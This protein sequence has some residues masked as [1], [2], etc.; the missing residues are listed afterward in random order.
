MDTICAKWL[1]AVCATLIKRRAPSAEPEVMTAPRAR[2]QNDPPSPP[3]RLPPRRGGRRSSCPGHGRLPRGRL[4]AQRPRGRR[5]R[6]RGRGEADRALAL[7]RGEAD[8]PALDLGGGGLRRG[9]A[10]AHTQ[11]RE[12][13]HGR[14][15]DGHGRGRDAEPGAVKSSGELLFRELVDGIWLASPVQ[16]YLDLMR[17]EGRARE[18]AKHL[19]QEKIGF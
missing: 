10:Q 17:G 3:D 7:C 11:G 12:S 19:R 4:H 8:R 18:M 15:H 1:E 16:V 13:L 6:G 14:S 9:R 2:E 5:L